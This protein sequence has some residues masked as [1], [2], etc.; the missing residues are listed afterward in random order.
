MREIFESEHSR[1]CDSLHRQ[2]SS[3]QQQRNSTLSTNTRNVDILSY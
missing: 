1:R 3:V 2:T